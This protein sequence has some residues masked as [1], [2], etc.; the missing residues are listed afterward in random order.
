M[1]SPTILEDRCKTG[2]PGLDEILSGGIP[3][4]GCV[5]VAGGPGSGKTILSIQFLYD[6]AKN[7]GEKGLLV[8]FDE[9]PDNIKKNM[10]K[11][12]W[13]ITE[14]EREGK[15][16]ILDLSDFIYLTQE[17]FHKK[18]YGVNVPEFTIVGAL[19]IIKENVEEMNAERVV[20]D[21]ITPIYIRGG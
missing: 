17:E 9:S 1:T 8:T 10:L 21:S 20:V 12:G 15:F 6:G 7:H 11:F 19:S 13:N 18:A 16:R 2:I 3:Q 14:L 4:G 5:L